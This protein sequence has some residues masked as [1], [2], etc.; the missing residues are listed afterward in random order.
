MDDELKHQ[1]PILL[2]INVTDEID[3]NQQNGEKDLFGEFNT[4]A[5]SN[6]TQLRGESKF[7]NCTL[8]VNLTLFSDP[9][10]SKRQYGNME[11]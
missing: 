8:S 10:T 1:N 4:T 9:H 11:I 5:M 3:T 7:E 2:T 6:E